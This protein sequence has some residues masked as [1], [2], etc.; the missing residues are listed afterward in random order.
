VKSLKYA[1]RV[2]HYLSPYWR[3]AVVSVVIMVIAGVVGLLVPWPLKILVDNILGHQPLPQWITRLTG[4]AA[5]KP[6]FR[7]L[8]CRGPQDRAACTSDFARYA[9]R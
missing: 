5:G 1:P 4:E 8:R 6:G 9:L 7:L 3:L 2:F